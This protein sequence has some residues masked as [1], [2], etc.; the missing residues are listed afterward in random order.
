MNS[1]LHRRQVLAGAAALMLGVS[2]VASGCSGESAAPGAAGD[3]TTLTIWTWSNEARAAFEGGISGAFEKANPGIKLDVLVQPDKDYQTLLTTGLSGSGGP[4]VAAIRS[5]G[6]ISSFADSGNLVPLNDIVTD[7]SGFSK[8]AMTGASSRSDGKIYAVPQGVQTAQ[9]Y[10]NKEIFAK[11]G[12]QVPTTWADLLK[13]S[14]VLKDAGVTPIAM[15]GNVAAQTALGGEVFGNARRGGDAFAAKF[16]K[17][18][19]DLN[20]ADNVASIQ[21]MADL[22]PYL[23]DN[24]T[25]VTLDEAVTLFTTGQAAMFAS[26]TWQVATFA[27]LN[28]KLDYGTFNAPAD[29]GWPSPEVTVAY[30]DGGWALSK[31]SE[32]PDQAK[33]LM[34]WLASTEFANLYANA[35]GTIPARDGVTL[36]NAQIQ[37]MYQRYLK[38]PS[39]YLGAAYLRYGNPWGTDIYGEQMQKIWLGQS[40]AKQAAAAIQTGIGAWFKPGDFK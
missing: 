37:E 8:L 15:P 16:L 6:V 19:T 17:G 36:Q 18:E 40:D 24:A 12:L 28:P 4:D 1:R 11:H 5:Y 22:Q 38:N 9:V 20:D 2:L 33:I 3:T 34:N 14:A 35:M 21:L 23:N 30:A 27:K 39:T 25:S 32:H 13:V 7:W 29:A 31:R 26:G 10:Y